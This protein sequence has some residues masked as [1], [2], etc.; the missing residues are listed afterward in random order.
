MEGFHWKAGV[1]DDTYTVDIYCN[2]WKGELANR[3]CT[4][5]SSEEAQDK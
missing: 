4:A 2:M 1:D 3:K 5:E